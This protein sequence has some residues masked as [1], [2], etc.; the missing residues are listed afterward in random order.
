[1]YPKEMFA[2]WY[3]LTKEKGGEGGQ[4]VSHQKGSVE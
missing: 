2:V 1:M 4:S 3:V